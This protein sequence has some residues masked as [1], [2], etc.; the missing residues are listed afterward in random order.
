MPTPESG[1]IETG[2][3]SKWPFSREECPSLT[4]VV[5]FSVR[6]MEE[7]WATLRSDDPGSDL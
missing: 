3:I 1:V 7:D 4:I 5:T 6:W 2:V